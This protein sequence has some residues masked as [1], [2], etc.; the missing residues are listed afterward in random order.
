M[1][2]VDELSENTTSFADRLSAMTDD[3]LFST[4]HGLEQESEVLA[5]RGGDAGDVLGRI[6]LVEGVIEDRYPGQALSPYKQWQ[7]QN[8]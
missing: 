2:M 5:K 7:R 8:F 1:M 6:A 3:E 4:M